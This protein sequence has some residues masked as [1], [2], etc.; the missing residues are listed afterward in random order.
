MVRVA[1]ETFLKH[2]DNYY[3]RIDEIYTRYGR[4]S[5]APHRSTLVINGN[6]LDA[7]KRQVHEDAYPRQLDGGK[8][9]PIRLSE[10]RFRPGDWETR[11]VRI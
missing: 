7:E 9:A 3:V 1:T 4:L 10:L 2:S 8:W 11:T 6:A 5:T